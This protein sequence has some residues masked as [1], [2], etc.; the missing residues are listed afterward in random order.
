MLEVRSVGSCVV[1]YGSNI[2]FGDMIT[3]SLSLSFSF[4]LLHAKCMGNFFLSDNTFATAILFDRPIS[5]S[6]FFFTIP[7]L[8]EL[9]KHPP[10]DR[11]HRDMAGPEPSG[12]LLPP[13]EHQPGPGGLQRLRRPKALHGGQGHH[14]VA[15]VSK[16]NFTFI[17]LYLQWL[18]DKG[19]NSWS[20]G[21]E[22]ESRRGNSAIY[23]V[24][25]VAV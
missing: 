22:I 11:L 5:S 6:K 19:P 25:S 16:R 23:L 2:L 15:D 20:G 8:Q 18:R 14:A 3:L 9:V 12:R 17:L 10:V 24:Q 13:Q 4:S 1:S 21:H 7:V